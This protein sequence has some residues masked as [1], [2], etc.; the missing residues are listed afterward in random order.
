[1]RKIRQKVAKFICK[2]INLLT[3]IYSYL[4][5]FIKY[6]TYLLNTLTYLLNILIN[7]RKIFFPSLNIQNVETLQEVGTKRYIL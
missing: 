7:E 5:S 6:L 3:Y 1:M 4:H 2:Y